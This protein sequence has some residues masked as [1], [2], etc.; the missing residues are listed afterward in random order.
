V[1]VRLLKRTWHRD[2]VAAP[3]THAWVLSLYRA[4]ELHP[5]T[6]ED[7]FPSWAAESPAL[8]ESMERHERDEARHVKMYDAAL[9]KLGAARLD[10]E[11]RDVFNVV[12]REETPAC[13]DVR[14]AGDAGERRLF[15]AHF[16]A[17]AHWLERRIAV[18]VEMHAEACVLAGKPDVARIVAA[19][20]A[21][22]VRHATYTA[23]AVRELVPSHVAREVME[24]H[25][26]GEARANL[27]FSARQVRSFLGAFA[28]RTSLSH[29]FLYRV[30]A[31]LMEGARARL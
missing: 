26:R 16:L 11:G 22:E 24:L 28:G 7:Y 5:Q 31:G 17:H 1:L 4:G 29:G 23:E 9:A 12:I 21:D 6:V 8:R 20:G 18:S 27:A 10:F 3:D 30:S 13:F 14:K 15:L 25:R 2:L 19:V